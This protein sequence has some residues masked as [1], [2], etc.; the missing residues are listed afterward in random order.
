MSD[1]VLVRDEGPVRWLTMNRP[2]K[3]NALNAELVTALE[4]ALADPGDA[5]CLAITGAG[6]NTCLFGLSIFAVS[7]IKL[8]PAKT[9]TSA[10]VSAAWRAKPRLSPRKSPISWTMGGI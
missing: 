5:R 8:T 3:R 4:E 7:P 1:L 6:S 2:E 9:M 10:S